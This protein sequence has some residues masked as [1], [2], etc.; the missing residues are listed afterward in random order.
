QLKRSGVSLVLTTHYMDEAEQLCDRVV[1]MDRGRIAAEGSP[2]DLIGT[3]ST[4]DVVELRF[5]DD[6]A[7]ASALAELTA[8]EA[9]IEPLAHRVRV[10]ADDGEARAEWL[11][12]PERQPATVALRRIQD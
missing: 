4:R 10:Y 6:A 5:D 11:A 2:R 8:A 1:I 3:H 9:R 7:R 12:R